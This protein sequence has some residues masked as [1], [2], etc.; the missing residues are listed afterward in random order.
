MS[1]A[2]ASRLYPAWGT[3]KYADIDDVD[4]IKLSVATAAVVKSYS[5]ATLDGTFA[6]PGPAKT[7]M[8]RLSV[9]TAVHAGTYN[10]TDAIT[11]TCTDQFGNSRTLTATLTNAN[12]GETVEFTLADG[13]DA[14]AMTVSQIDVPAQNDALGSFEFGVT[15]VVFDDPARQVRGGAN[16]DIAVEYEAALL[17]GTAHQDVLPCEQGEHHDVFAKKILDTGTTAFPVT[18]YL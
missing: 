2:H 13:S 15:D 8:H 14:G 4:A 11:A 10:I 16:G 1:M 12:G 6:N 17:T 7:K 5:G 9:T 3:L 18:A